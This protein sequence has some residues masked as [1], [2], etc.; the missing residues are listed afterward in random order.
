[1]PGSEA[2]SGKT[3]QVEAVLPQL[4][5]AAEPT[6]PKQVIVKPKPAG[7]RKESSCV[8]VSGHWIAKC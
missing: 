6:L 3:P 1:M 8:R 5:Q 2:S 7:G 4:S